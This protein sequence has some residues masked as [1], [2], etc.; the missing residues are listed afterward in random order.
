MNFSAKDL[1]LLGRARTVS[2]TSSHRFRHGAVLVAHGKVQS[3]G[4]NYTRNNPRNVQ[5]RSDSSTHA[6]VAAL[7]A[8]R[9]ETK[10]MTMF[11]V[12]SRKNG[13]TAQSRPCNNCQKAIIK[14]GVKRVVYTTDQVLVYG[15]W[16]PGI[17][18]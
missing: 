11:V 3:V 18:A 17:H 6:E 12:R 2:L 5:F 16:Y 13:E 9:G 7:N 10:G 4:I 8:I 1:D 14:A 15:V